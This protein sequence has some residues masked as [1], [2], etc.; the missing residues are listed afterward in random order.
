MVKNR[1]VGPHKGEKHIVVEWFGLDQKRE[2]WQGPSPPHNPQDCS[3]LPKKL[4][5]T[6]RY[7]FTIK[8][9]F[10][11]GINTQKY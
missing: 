3:L 6:W 8:K 11:F 10:I 5:V 4:I 1:F 7:A 9:N 2:Q